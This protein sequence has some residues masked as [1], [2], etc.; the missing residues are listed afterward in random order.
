MSDDAPLPPLFVA[1]DGRV[2]EEVMSRMRKVRAHPDVAALALL[3]DAH[4]A[5]A[6]CVGVAMAT[7]Q[8]LWPAAVGGDIGCGMATV[9]LGR[10]RAEIP[11]GLL[12][13][14]LQNL[15]RTIPSHRHPTRQDV[16]LDPNGLSSPHLS[17]V[18]ERDGAVQFATLGRGN[19]FLEL[20]RDNESRLWLTT[21]TGS[22]AI[23][24]AVSALHLQPDTPLLADSPQGQAYLRDSNWCRQY[25]AASR[26]EIL[27]RAATQV[28]EVL[29]LTDPNL[30]DLPTHIACD[31]NHLQRETHFGTELYLH[32]KGV[33]PAAAGEWG[34]IA[35]SMGT[36][37][38]LTQGRGHPDALQSSSHG[39]GRRLTR[40]E[41]RAAIGAREL[42]R[43]MANVCFDPRLEPALVEEAPTAY[44]DIRRVLRA[45]RDLT[46][47][48]L[49]LQPILVHKAT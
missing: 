8:T 25:A 46:G 15:Q 16:P 12:N 45:Q 6:F 9:C 10:L 11:H 2:P 18:A 4:V 17:R 3:P 31:H 22:R 44:R 48:R 40:S 29:D 13:Q 34:I 49:E 41:A 19:H 32:R 24:A 43:Q 7:H 28:R 5:G 33:T 37:T 1:F 27:T 30:D 36:A 21:H 23:G 26:A 20:Q 39:A 14:L 47:I 35:G 38:F 42:R